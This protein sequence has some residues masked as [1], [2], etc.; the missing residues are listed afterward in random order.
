MITV[1]LRS[2]KPYSNYYGPYIILL[3]NFKTDCQDMAEKKR[4]A[5]ADAAEARGKC[6]V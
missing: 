3:N 2:P 5:D 4:K 1:V 6:L